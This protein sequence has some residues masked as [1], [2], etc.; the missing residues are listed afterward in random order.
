VDGDRLAIEG[1]YFQAVRNELLFE[2]PEEKGEMVGYG[3]NFSRLTT[4]K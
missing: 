2:I 3:G 1:N 4:W